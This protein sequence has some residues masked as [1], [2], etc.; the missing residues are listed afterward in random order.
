M[1]D[2]DRER[3]SY[4]A[5][6][7]HAH[8]HADRARPVLRRLIRARLRASRS[9]ASHGS[10]SSPRKVY[11]MKIQLIPIPEHPLVHELERGAPE[12]V[13]LRRRLP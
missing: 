1:E 4:A 6:A 5:F 12:L 3:L 11:P 7:V 10:F 13:D 2:Y 9:V 8:G